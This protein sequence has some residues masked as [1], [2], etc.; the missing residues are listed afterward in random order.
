MN[1]TRYLYFSPNVNLVMCRNVVS[2]HE[3]EFVE[4]VGEKDVENSIL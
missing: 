4:D 2:F 3:N 1:T